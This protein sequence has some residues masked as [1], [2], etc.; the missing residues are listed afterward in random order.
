[1]KYFESCL[2]QTHKYKVN[3][4][5]SEENLITLSDGIKSMS[6]C[7]LDAVASK[8]HFEIPISFT[9]EIEFPCGLHLFSLIKQIGYFTFKLIMHAIKVSYFWT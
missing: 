4:W 6:E 2:A 5:T 7:L 1:M 8:E 9:L 3:N